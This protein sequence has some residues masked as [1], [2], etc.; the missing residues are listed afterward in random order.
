MTTTATTPPHPLAW[1]EDARE[2]EIVRDDAGS[3]GPRYTP[4]P[5][6]T[7]AVA[8]LRVA[9]A[10]EASGE[11]VTSA[12]TYLRRMA[13]RVAEEMVKIALRSQNDH[14]RR[15]AGRD[16]FQAVGLLHET[17]RVDVV[18][19]F[20]AIFQRMTAEELD[21]FMD[22]REFPERLRDEAL[23]LLEHAG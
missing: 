16:I 20:R 15:A 10:H 11:G 12:L 14:A 4:T 2:P 3:D 13:P 19:S 21:R 23:K 5:Q 17:T 18:L 6:Q 1:V 22:V 8:A 9:R 7:G